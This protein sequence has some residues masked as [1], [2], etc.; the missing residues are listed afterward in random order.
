[1]MIPGWR[2]EQWL[3]TTRASRI[4]RARPTS[5]AADD[6][7][8]LLKVV[9]GGDLADFRG[10]YALAQSLSAPG[11]FRPR[12]LWAEGSVLAMVLDDGPLVSLE[13]LLSAQPLELP[14][15]LR[16][17]HSIARALGALHAAHLVHGDVRP[18]NLLVEPRTHEVL[19]ADL[20]AAAELSQPPAPVNDWAYVSP[21][22]TGR[23]GRMIDHRADFYALGVLLYRLLCGRLPFQ[24]SDPLE[25]LHCQIARTPHAPVEVVPQLPRVV[26]DLVMKLLAKAPE[27]RYHGA[28]GLLV[29]L[30]HCLDE[31]KSTGAI[32]W[33]SLGRDDVSEQLQIPQKL[34]GRENERTARGYRCTELVTSAA[35]VERLLGLNLLAGH[36]AKRAAALVAAQ[37]Y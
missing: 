28:H 11:I 35:E 8:V 30:Q 36:K 5:E 7:A 1:M 13:T 3:A 32:E 6:A 20:S 24:A 21:E 4:A 15:C 33:F 29:D 18:A 25:W 37:E 26:S 16:A 2:L 27:D 19:I 14:A 23:T 12:S 9:A 31:W 17:A 22:Q 34:Y 10:E